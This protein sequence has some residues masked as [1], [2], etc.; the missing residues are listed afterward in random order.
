MC[1]REDLDGDGEVFLLFVVQFGFLPSHVF[2]ALESGVRGE[3]G[4]VSVSDR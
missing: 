4:E 3:F 1:F 2:V